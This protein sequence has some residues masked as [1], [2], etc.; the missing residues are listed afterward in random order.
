MYRLMI[1]AVTWS[2]T[3]RTKYPSPHNSPPH[4]FRLSQGK[5]ANNSLADTLFN[6]CITRAG[7]SVVGRIEIH[8]RG[9]PSLP[10]Y[11]FPYH[12]LLLLHHVFLSSPPLPRQSE[13]LSCISV[14]RRNGISGHRSHAHLLWET[15]TNFISPPGCPLSSLQQA[16]GM[17]AGFIYKYA[18]NH[19]LSLRL[20]WT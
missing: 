4:S 19:S 13:A 3:E 10:M 17:K 12:M 6:I 8:A 2:P 18:R 15:C 5:R 11:L 20:S 7:S 16:V 1:S 9:L 14:S